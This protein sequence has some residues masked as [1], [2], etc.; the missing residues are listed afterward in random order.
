MAK[1]KNVSPPGVYLFSDTFDTLGFIKSKAKRWEVIEAIFNYYCRGIKPKDLGKEQLVIFNAAKTVLDKN[2]AR[3][4]SY[5]K[6]AKRYTKKTKRVT[7]KNARE[8]KAN[9]AASKNLKLKENKEETSVKVS[10]NPPKSEQKPAAG[11]MH[12]DN[13]LIK[14]NTNNVTTTISNSISK[15]EKEIKEKESEA[16]FCE[17]RDSETLLNK[18]FLGADAGSSKCENNNQFVEPTL[19]EIKEYIQKCEYMVDAKAFYFFYKSKGWMVGKTLICDW[20][21]KVD[22]WENRHHPEPTDVFYTKSG[23]KYRNS[24]FLDM[25]LGD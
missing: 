1:T 8:N 16:I 15:K 7:A 5:S 22:E 17:E 14:S 6:K 20:K 19:E 24:D 18:G 2:K 25:G 4:A 12:I 9:L 13:I 11:E 10:E 21:A 3:W 23:R